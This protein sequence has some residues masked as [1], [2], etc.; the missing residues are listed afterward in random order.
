MLDDL[1]T[2]RLGAGPLPDRHERGQPR[3]RTSRGSSSHA[4][5]LRR[6]GR[7]TRSTTT[8]CSPSRARRRARSSR[9]SPTRRCP[10][11]C[12]AAQ[13][14]LA[15][16]ARRSSAAPATPARTAS[17]CC[18]RPRTP[19]RVWD[20]LVAPRRRARRPGA[21]DTLRLEVCFHLY[22]NDLIEE[23][24]PIEAGLG[25]C[26]KED[27][28]FIGADAVR[29]VRE[30]GPAEKLAPVPPRPGPGIAAPGQP[31]RRRRRGH[32][33]HAVAVPR[34]RDRHGLRA[35]RA[36]RRRAPRS[37]STS[38]ARPRAAVVAEQAPLPQGAEMADASYP[39]DLLYHAEHDWARIDGDTAD[40]R[41][42]LV[43]PGRAR[44]GRV[45]RPARGR[46]DASRRT[47]P[48]PRSSRSRRSPTSSRRCRARSSRSTP[49]SATSP[50]RSTRTPTATGW[51]VKV[52]A[53]R[54]SPSSDDAAGRATPTQRPD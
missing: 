33:R 16:R 2:Y 14:T 24:G 3:A 13:R 23:R 11:A 7:A 40:V 52:Q 38:A 30:A 4:D 27:T 20:E 26:C 41:D 43:R 1:F 21:R 51:M 29:A 12:T 47:S 50:R 34:R 39:D 17:S 32:E 28:G 8:R 36:G 35:G 31:D 19:P 5:G 42:H 15:R 44:R 18:S 37:R 22:G 46:H 10:R 6:R 25:W 48:T 54:P 9:R 45:L 49:R 53:L